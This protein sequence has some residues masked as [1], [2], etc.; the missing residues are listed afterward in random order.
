MWH[1]HIWPRATGLLFL[2]GRLRFCYVTGKEAGAA[3][4]PSVLVA[5]GKQDARDLFRAISFGSISGAYVDL[6]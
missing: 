4:A 6:R 1:E 2:R 3:A 5:Y